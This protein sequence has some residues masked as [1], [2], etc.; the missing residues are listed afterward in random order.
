MCL[1]FCAQ[2]GNVASC[3]AEPRA[4]RRAVLDDGRVIAGDTPVVA[5]EFEARSG[6]SAPSSA[7]SRADQSLMVAITAPAVIVRHCH[8]DQCPRIVR[9]VQNYQNRVRPHRTD[10][11]GVI[12]DCGATGLSDHSRHLAEEIVKRLG[13]RPE[14]RS[15]IRNKV[16]YVSAL[17]DDEVTKLEGAE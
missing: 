5:T 10:D 3:G 14:S 6:T 15:D 2:H 8:A 4:A 1:R 7:V 17:F 16:R 9:V 11:N 12:C 13:L